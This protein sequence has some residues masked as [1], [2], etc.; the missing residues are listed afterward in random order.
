MRYTYQPATSERVSLVTLTQPAH[1]LRASLA[2]AASLPHAAQVA[3]HD[4]GANCFV[5]I[6][7]MGRQA[8][9]GLP[10]KHRFLEGSV[11]EVSFLAP[12]LGPLQNVMVGPE[13]GRWFCDEIDVY[14]S[15]TGHTDRWG[16]G[17]LNDCTCVCVHDEFLFA[18]R[19]CATAGC[20]GVQGTCQAVCWLAGWGCGEGLCV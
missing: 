17:L 2:H 18:T 19:R 12:E 1:V 6:D 16:R 8:Q 5:A 3:D 13:Q 15:R 10:V 14:S 4:T 20:Y 11:D 7:G 9:R